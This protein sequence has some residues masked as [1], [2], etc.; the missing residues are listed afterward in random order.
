MSGI[1]FYEGEDLQNSGAN[2]KVIGVG[3]CGGNA[4]QHMIDH[5]IEGVEFVCANTDAQ[6]LEKSTAETKV[7]LGQN[8]TRGRGAGSKP[9]IGREACKEN[10]EQMQ[11]ILD[12]TE[13]LFL[14]SGMGGG[15]GTGASPVIAE[16]AKDL[17]I[18]TVAVVTKPFEFEG[19]A[20]MKIAEAGI[21]ELVEHVDSIIIVPNEKLLTELPEDITMED[22]YKQSDSVLKGAVQGI[23]DLITHTGKMNVDFADVN[24]VMQEAGQAMMGT[25]IAS[26]ENRAERAADIAVRSPL[27]E[28]IELKDAKALLVNITASKEL[29][30][31]EFASASNKV[32][33][34]AAPEANIIIGSVV[35]ESLGDNVKVTVVATGLGGEYAK[36]TKP[37]HTIVEK[38]YVS[39]EVYR[40]GT[41][42]QSY[43]V[44]EELGSPEEPAAPETTGGYMD[45]PA[46]LRR[47]T[48]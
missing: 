16:I 7:A 19:A 43:G 3:G 18:L 2:I 33:E 35:D 28:G 37:K 8:K 45:I 11:G 22:A 20:R 14:T 41:D 31:H 48:D 27:L 12:G 6:D 42:N 39:E 46:F 21:K 44:V 13:M 34:M 1:K 17:N 40:T 30:L 26:G 9:E 47:Q 4:V 23:A 10:I 15:T 24:T 36:K 32:K 5:N 29:G 25:G 38:P